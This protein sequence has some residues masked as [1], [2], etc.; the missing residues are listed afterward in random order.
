MGIRKYMNI[1]YVRAEVP[2]GPSMT[3]KN[4]LPISY[5]I[6][7]A[8]KMASELKRRKEEKRRRIVALAA[9]KLPLVVTAP[10]YHVV[11]LPFLEEETKEGRLE[12]EMSRKILGL[13]TR[14]IIIDDDTPCRI[15]INLTIVERSIVRHVT[16]DFIND[17]DEH[18][19]HTSGISDNDE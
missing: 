19:S 8:S 2:D 5:A 7:D 18:L 11:L 16:D 9:P 14:L 6:S 12:D 4:M 3:S 10:R 13:G 17:I 15:D 1:N